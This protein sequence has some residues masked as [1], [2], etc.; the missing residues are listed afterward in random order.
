VPSAGP[1]SV[2]NATFLRISNAGSA[3][4]LSCHTK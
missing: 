3:V 4:C 1:G 2:F